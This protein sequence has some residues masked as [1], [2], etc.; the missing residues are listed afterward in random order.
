MNWVSIYILEGGVLL[1]DNRAHITAQL[2]QCG[3]QT[4]LWADSFERDPRRF[5]LHCFTQRTR[6]G[7]LRSPSKWSACSIHLPLRG[8]C[9]VNRLA[10]LRDLGG[11]KATEFCVSVDERFIF[12]QIHTE[13]LVGSKKGF[14]P[15]NIWSKLA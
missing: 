9:G 1:A 8:S 13:H 3:D 2:I 10:D 11:K 5:R 12:G 6:A 7:T 14:R 4:H 15:L